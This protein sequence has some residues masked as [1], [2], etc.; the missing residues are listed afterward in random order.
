M[1]KSIN[2]GMDVL[3]DWLTDIENHKLLNTVR[4][5]AGRKPG[6]VR[7][8]IAEH[9]IEPPTRLCSRPRGRTPLQSTRRS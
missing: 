9:V 6:N 4:P 1:E 7:K 3:V 8:L 2:P 5:T